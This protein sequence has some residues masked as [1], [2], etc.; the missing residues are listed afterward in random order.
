MV[1]LLHEDLVIACVA[2]MRASRLNHFATE[3]NMENKVRERQFKWNYA[4]VQTSCVIYNVVVVPE[5]F[6]DNNMLSWYFAVPV[7]LWFRSCLGMGMML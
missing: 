4:T 6:V 5:I 3:N 2:R 7:F 1:N